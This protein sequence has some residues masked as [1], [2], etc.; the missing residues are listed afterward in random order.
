M[1]YLDAADILQKTFEMINGIPG[2]ENQAD[3]DALMELLRN[4]DEKVN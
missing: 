2:K 4:M 3:K 1:V